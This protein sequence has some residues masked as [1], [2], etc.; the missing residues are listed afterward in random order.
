MSSRR[1]TK[2]SSLPSASKASSPTALQVS[3]EQFVTQ[4]FQQQQQQS[5]KGSSLSRGITHA[6]LVALCQLHHAFLQSL[7]A[8]LVV[9]MKDPSNKA[10]SSKKRQRSSTSM[11]TLARVNLSHI[12]AALQSLGMETLW[13]EVQVVM[14]GRLQSNDETTLK[15]E[16]QSRPTDTTKTNAQARRKNKKRKAWSAEELAEQERLLEESRRKLQKN[17]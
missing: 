1:H 8:A 10:T 7:A 17:T 14:D 15:K 9:A 3:M 6:G 5:E 11:S 2:S 16:P 13:Q 4:Y 12:E